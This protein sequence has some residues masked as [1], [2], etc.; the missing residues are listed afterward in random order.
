MS[1]L[2]PKFLANLLVYVLGG[3]DEAIPVPDLRMVALNADY[4]FDAAHQN[5][6]DVPAEAILATSQILD[7]T[8]E[9]DATLRVATTADLF[10][11]ES[12]VDCTSIVLYAHYDVSDATLLIAHFDSWANTGVPFTAPTTV[13]LAFQ[14]DFVFRLG[15]VGPA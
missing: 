2:Y 11:G 14:N 9:E 15:N 4:T 6:D 3:T 1:Q 7:A 8:V 12:I 13:A 5:L 10:E